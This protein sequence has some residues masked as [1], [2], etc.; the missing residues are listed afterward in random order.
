MSLLF[1]VGF[2]TGMEGLTYPIPFSDPETL[3][4]LAQHA[5]KLGY[6]SVWGNDH[7]TTQHYVRAEFPVPPRFWEPLVTYS[8]LAAQTTTLRFG[9]GVLVLPMRRDIVVTAKQ[10]ATLDHLSNGRAEIGVG[11]GAYREEFE[12]L[13]PGAKVHRGD[14][15][16]E[17]VRALQLLFSERVASFDG[18][19]YK[20]KDVELFPKP[21]QK[22]LPIYFGGNN[23]NHLRRAA[24]SADGWIPA[25]LPR[26]TLKSMVA[27]LKR[28]TEAEGRD[29][30]QMQ[31]AP[32]YVVHLGKDQDK[33]VA[34]YRE[35]QM[36][37]H[38]ESLKKS[39]LKQQSATKSEDINLVGSFERVIERAQSF[40][41]A[42][43]THF[44]GLFFAANSPDELMDQ[45]QMFAEEIKPHIR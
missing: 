5:E 18:E 34:R 15:V 38:L 28:M 4:R 37:K 36:F 30:S 22:R 44:L 10:I 41:D 31:I 42:G 23:A 21:K 25:A 35:S 32:Q 7:M 3:V 8:Y 12:A 26:E 13:N 9:T 6:H 17:G 40:R 11:V 24:K 14:M 20:F 2:P 39:T 33:A 1:S 43:V 29:F 16:E 19:Y 45:M 27:E